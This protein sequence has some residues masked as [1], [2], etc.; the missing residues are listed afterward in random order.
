MISVIIP[1]Y[2][3]A[4]FI[5]SCYES[6]VRQSWTDWEAIFIDDGSNDETI[7]KLNDIAGDPRVK[8]IH[9]KNEGVAIARE[10]GMKEA[11]GDY[12]TFLDIDDTIVGDA[13]EKYILAFDN[14][15]ID[16]VVSGINIVNN[17]GI[18]TQCISYSERIIDSQTAIDD[19]CDGNLRWQLCSKAFRKHVFNNVLTP[20]RIK[21]AEDMAVCIQATANANHIKVLGDCLY[22]YV[23]NTLSVTHIKG[24]TIS[25]DAL[26]ATYFVKHHIGN[27]INPTSLDCLFL[28]IISGALKAGIDK[29]DIIFIK[30]LNHHFNIK[31]LWRLPARKALA[32]IVFKF[33]KFNPTLNN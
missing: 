22:N 18:I 24:K 26:N 15:L 7:I 5:A 6:L 16:I 3:G 21:N 32:L 9:K 31:A 23:Q 2:N 25:I 8:I 27:I 17:D 10:V 28:L 19:L 11:S 33:F 20:K 13:L 4:T 14:E 29:N 12:I 1:V 30:T